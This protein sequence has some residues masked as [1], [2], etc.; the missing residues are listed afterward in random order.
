MGLIL[1]V[2]SNVRRLLNH[3]IHLSYDAS[4]QIAGR[5]FPFVSYPGMEDS[6]V[7]GLRGRV[8]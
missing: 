4:K 1:I 7:Y 3:I 2:V 5:S 6:L 8:T